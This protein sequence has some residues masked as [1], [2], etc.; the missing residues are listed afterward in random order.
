MVIDY[1]HNIK[2][3]IRSTIDNEINKIYFENTINFNLIIF[4]G[5]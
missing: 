5:V 1:L 2:Y 3:N 4:G